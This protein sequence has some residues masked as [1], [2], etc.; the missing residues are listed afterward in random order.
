[1]VT[2]GIQDLQVTI[3]FVKAD[4]EELRRIQ[5]DFG[6]MSRLKELEFSFKDP[7]KI[8]MQGKIGYMIVNGTTQYLKLPQ[9][10][11]KKRDEIG[12]ASAKRHSLLDIGVFSRSSLN[13]ATGKFVREDAVDGVNAVVFEVTYSGDPNTK[14]LVWLRA[15]NHAVVK[16]EWVDSNGKLKATFLYQDLKEVKP[17]IWLPSKVEIRNG[18]GVVAGL[19]SSSDIKINLGLKDSLFD[20]SN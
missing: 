7:D 17:G 18:D 12:P 16:R 14:N 11:I 13:S 1:M 5:R 19:L 10:G 15:D 8:R 3:T 2:D 20:T 4:A 9:L 6:F